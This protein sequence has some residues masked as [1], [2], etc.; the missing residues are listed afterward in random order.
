MFNIVL[1]KCLVVKE[2]TTA[3]H[4][5]T[6][7]SPPD[8]SPV[9]DSAYSAHM[10][11]SKTPIIDSG[12]STHIVLDQTFFRSYSFSSDNIS[13]FDNSQSVIAGRGEAQLL[14]SRPSGGTIN[15]K[16][17][18]IC[19]VPSLS[20]P[21]VSVSRLDNTDWYTLFG[22]GHCVTFELKNNGQMIHDIL[23]KSRHIVLTT[24]R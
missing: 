14:A 21:I 6:E 7:P 18:D 24:T 2:V 20:L 15:L 16:L 10:V 17:R 22:A 19:H 1:E 4:P 23:N 11:P 9:E 13:S 3:T 12:T 5:P 8:S